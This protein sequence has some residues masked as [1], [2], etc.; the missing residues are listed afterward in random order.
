[1]RYVLPS[2]GHVFVPQ[3]IYEDR[4][5]CQNRDEGVPLGHPIT[6]PKRLRL[7]SGLLSSNY[8]FAIGTHITLCILPWKIN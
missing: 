7:L 4:L 8:G 2:I 1:M 5:A 6:A 3:G